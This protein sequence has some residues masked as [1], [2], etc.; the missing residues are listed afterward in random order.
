MNAVIIGPLATAMTVAFRHQV[1]N[2]RARCGQMPGQR[3][4]FAK[5]TTIPDRPFAFC[6]GIEW[7]N[8]NAQR[9]NSQMGHDRSGLKGRFRILA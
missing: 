4:F 9:C 1:S 8:A 5:C 3:C 7:Q 6:K 2:R